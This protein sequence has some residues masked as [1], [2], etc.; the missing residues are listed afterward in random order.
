MSSQPALLDHDVGW[1]PLEH[2]LRRQGYQRVAGLDE[3]GRGCLAGPVVAAAVVLP[4]DARLPG[5]ADSK[6]LSHA[7]RE[8]ALLEIQRVALAVGVGS[9]SAAEIDEHNILGATRMAMARAVAQLEPPPDFL[10]IDGN[11]SIPLLLPQ[12]SVVKGDARCLSIAAA[13]IVAKVTRDR[14]IIDAAGR[15]PAYGFER[16]KGYGTREHLEALRVHGPCPIHRKTFRGVPL[17]PGEGAR[18]LEPMP[19]HQK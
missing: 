6:R 9:A 14:W 4:P 2:R 1:L 8:A 7:R 15:F 18:S 3:A 17:P 5:V 10:L 16:H 12:R 11:F 13:S 19:R